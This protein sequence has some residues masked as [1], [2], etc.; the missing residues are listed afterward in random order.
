M[1]SVRGDGDDAD[2]QEVVGV[3]EVF[4]EPLQR[5]LQQGFDAVDRHLVTLLLTWM[6]RSQSVAHFS[7]VLTTHFYWKASSEFDFNIFLCFVTSN[8]NKG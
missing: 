3:A 8:Q 1:A 5:R 2:V 7:S 6:E 4:A